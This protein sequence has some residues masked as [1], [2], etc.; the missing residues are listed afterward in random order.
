MSNPQGFNK[1]SNN[2]RQSARMLMQA[3]HGVRHKLSPRKVGFKQKLLDPMAHFYKPKCIR[4]AKGYDNAKRQLKMAWSELYQARQSMKRSD[5]SQKAAQGKLRD[6]RKLMQ[7][8]KLQL[9]QE[10][11]DLIKKLASAHIAIEE[12]GIKIKNQ[13]NTMWSMHQTNR[14]LSLRAARERIRLSGIKKSLSQLSGNPLIKNGIYTRECCRFVILGCPISSVGPI[15]Q[16]C[17]EV[18][19]IKPQVPSL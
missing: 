2:R 14:A 11:N 12:A 15:L 9:V 3:R 6:L 19:G 13:R 17:S 10:H 16:S 4:V 1:A 18:L 8:T 7:S 5:N